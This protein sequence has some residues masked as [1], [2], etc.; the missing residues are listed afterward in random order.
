MQTIPK[1]TLD[2]TDKPTTPTLRA[3][4]DA[5]VARYA[6]TIAAIGRAVLP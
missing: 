2:R 5:L 3:R 6:A 1:P 4:L